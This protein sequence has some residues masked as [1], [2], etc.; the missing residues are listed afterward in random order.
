MVEAENVASQA[1]LQVCRQSIANMVFLVT[2][3]ASTFRC[4]TLYYM[5]AFVRRIRAICRLLRM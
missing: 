4:R 3:M 5:D 1:S 2:E